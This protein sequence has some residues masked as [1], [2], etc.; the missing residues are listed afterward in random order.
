MSDDPSCTIGASL[1]V[2]L[3][4][5]AVGASV[6]ILYAPSAGSDTRARLND[7][8]SRLRERAADLGHEVAEKARGLRDRAA[9]H[10]A[11]D[12]IIGAD[13]S[14]TPSEA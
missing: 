7:T 13:T 8:A 3:L 1:V 2:F 6:A 12:P 9:A 5:V 14:A 11:D 4:G 10:P